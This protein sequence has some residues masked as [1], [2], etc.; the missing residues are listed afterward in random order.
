MA[1]NMTMQAGSLCAYKP[2]SQ[3]LTGFS[4]DREPVLSREL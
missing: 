1:S 2:L 3:W 4:P